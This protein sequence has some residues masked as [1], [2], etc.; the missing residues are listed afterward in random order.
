MPSLGRSVLASACIL[1]TEC[2]KG[3]NWSILLTCVSNIVVVHCFE[4]IGV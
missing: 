1:S 3:R 4:M 2:Y